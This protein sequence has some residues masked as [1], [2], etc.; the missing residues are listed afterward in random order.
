LKVKN[1]SIQGYTQYVLDNPTLFPNFKGNVDRMRH[2]EKKYK[3]MW[4]LPQKIF[5]KL[6]AERGRYVDQSQSTNIYMADCSDAKLSA[7]HLYTNQLGLKTQL[8][9]LRQN[10]GST[11]KF[12]ADPSIIKHIQGTA[13]GSTES[14][15]Q[16]FVC[17]EEVCTACT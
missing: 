3:T 7:C 8:Y 15:K 6:A 14:D 1:G 9:Y 10:G 11:I 16:K 2:V 4:E 13:V 17:T 12:T 5:L